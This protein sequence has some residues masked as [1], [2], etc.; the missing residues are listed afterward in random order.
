MSKLKIKIIMAIVVVIPILIG[1]VFWLRQADSSRSDIPDEAMADSRPFDQLSTEQAKEIEQQEVE[2]YKTDATMETYQSDHGFSFKHTGLAV[3]SAPN[4]A[5]DLVIFDKG[6][7]SFQIFVTPFDEPG[8]ITP[9]RIE[10][11]LPGLQ[12][13]DIQYATLDGVKTIFFH[14]N[15]SGLDTYEAWMVTRGRMYQVL[16][17]RG[18]ED[19]LHQVLGTWQWK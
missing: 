2:Q 11:D 12:M 17:Y 14:S 16:T 1:V 4:V 13:N 18:M 10:Q 19:F 15:A 3:S 9:E 7:L 8:P 5:G 6:P